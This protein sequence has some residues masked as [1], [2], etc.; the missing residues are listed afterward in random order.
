MAQSRVSDRYAEFLKDKPP[1]Q[2]T[3]PQRQSIAEALVSEH[4]QQRPPE[5]FAPQVGM[6]VEKNIQSQPMPPAVFHEIPV[7]REYYYAKLDRNLLVIDPMT[8]KAVDVIPRKWP[9]AGEKPLDAS[10]W[11]ATRGRELLGL[12]PESAAETT[13]TSSGTR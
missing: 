6:T 5:G 12:A 9:S 2:L 7:L 8:S 3:Q 10:K 4:T 11:A 1:L 13:G